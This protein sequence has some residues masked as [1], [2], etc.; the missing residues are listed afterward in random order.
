MATSRMSLIPRRNCGLCFPASQM[1]SGGGSLGRAIVLNALDLRWRRVREVMRPR[2]EIV[3]LDTDASISECL[4]LADKTRYSRFPLAQAGD[5]DQ[6]LGVVHI[7]D[8]YAM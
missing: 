3:A 5:L 1:R 6:T 8:L 4:D 7:K 2:Q